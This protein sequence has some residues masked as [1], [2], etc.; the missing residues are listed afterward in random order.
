MTIQEASEKLADELSE[1]LKPG[2]VT[3]ATDEVDTIYIY[4]HLMVPGVYMKFGPL[5]EG[6]K[7][8]RKRV[9]KIRPAS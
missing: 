1:W 2:A 8:V 7:L 6:F 9:G 3:V 5:Y 4:E